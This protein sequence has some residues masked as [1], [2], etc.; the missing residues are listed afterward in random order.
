M[1]ESRHDDDEMAFGEKLLGM[2]GFSAARAAR[3]RVEISNL[4]VHRMA[5]FERW[6][7]AVAGALVGAQMLIFGYLMATAS[8]R[9]PE[10]RGFAEARWTMAAAMAVTGAFLGTWLLWIAIRGG[11]ARRTGDVIGLLV[12]I[13][14]CVGM[15]VTFA[16]IA[17]ATDDS[18]LGSKILLASVAMVALA[19]GCFFVALLQRMHRQTQEKLLRIEYHLAELMERGDG[20]SSK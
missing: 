8:P 20:S 19:A 1:S 12:A 6:I 13:I 3:Y 16:E 4:L 10:L 14:F 11:Y 2:Q 5:I 7:V 9:R 17:W 15:G 18:V